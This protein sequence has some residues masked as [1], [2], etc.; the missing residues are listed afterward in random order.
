MSPV[1][2]GVATKVRSP[3]LFRDMFRKKVFG[4]CFYLSG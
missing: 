1:M 4:L 2:Q 3:V